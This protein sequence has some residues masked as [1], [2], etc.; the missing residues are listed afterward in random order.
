MTHACSLWDRPQPLLNL[1]F[2]LTVLHFTLEDWTPSTSHLKFLYFSFI[3]HL[4]VS[5]WDILHIRNP[6]R[7]NAY[8]NKNKITSTIVNTRLQNKLLHSFLQNKHKSRYQNLARHVDINSR[9]L[10]K[11]CMSCLEACNRAIY[12][13]IKCKEAVNCKEIQWK[14]RLELYTQGCCLVVYKVGENLKVSGSN[15]IRAYSWN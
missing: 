2:A 13:K 11:V 1:L 5:R 12:C 15:P 3:S 4:A 14:V 7:L 10:Y 8:K 6:N 9:K